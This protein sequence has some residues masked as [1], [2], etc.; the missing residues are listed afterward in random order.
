MTLDEHGE[1]HIPDQEAQPIGEERQIAQGRTKQL[2]NFTKKH[3]E[4]AEGGSD[5]SGDDSLGPTV[6]G[7]AANG[8]DSDNRVRSDATRWQPPEGKIPSKPK[9]IGG[10]GNKIAFGPWFMGELERCPVGQVADFLSESNYGKWYD[11]LAV[12]NKDEFA[13]AEGLVN[14]KCE[15]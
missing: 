2:E 13:R 14:S 15:E 3:G 5:E 8:S 11:W 6:V 4:T 1:I 9:E 7:T 10:E 12:H